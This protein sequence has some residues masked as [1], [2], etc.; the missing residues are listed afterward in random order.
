[1]NLYIRLLLY[2]LT[3]KFRGRLDFLE[4]SSLRLHVW[5]ND[6][7]FNMHMNNGRYLTIMDLG[8]FDLMLRTGLFRKAMQHGGF[9]PML[10]AAKIRFRLPLSPFQPY[11]L[12]TR[13]ICWD[14]KW[15][16]MEQRFVIAK[17]PKAGAVAALAIVKGGLYDSK[18]K[19]I[20]PPAE[21]LK[22]IGQTQPSPPIPDY[23]ADI[24][25]AED[26]LK[27]LTV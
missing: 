14:E 23:I 10:G 21:L 18:N 24:Q 19:T 25:K 1:M 8:R 6:L 26:S 11:D 4:T 20:T 3:C 17:G 9:A 22:L 5:P 2:F 16:Y 13:M 7:D 27:T 12:Q 15:A